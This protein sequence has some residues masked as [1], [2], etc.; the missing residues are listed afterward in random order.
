[1]KLL[2]VCIMRSMGDAVAPVRLVSATDL[3]AFKYFSYLPYLLTLPYLTSTIGDD[4]MGGRSYFTRGTIAEHLKFATRTVGTQLY[5]NQSF[6]PKD[7]G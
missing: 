7:V 2:M 6:I 1:M 4:V 3:N 5:T